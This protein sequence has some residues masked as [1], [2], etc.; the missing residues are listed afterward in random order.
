MI[1]EKTVKQILEE[2]FC[3][4][5]DVEAQSAAVLQFLKDKGMASEEEL[6]PYF[7]QAKTSSGVRW[8]A[9]RAR[10]DYLLSSVIK[11]EEEAASEAREGTQAE[12]SQEASSAETNDQRTNIDKQGDR[13]KDDAQADGREKEKGEKQGPEPP[14]QDTAA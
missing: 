7:E 13:E 2:I 8:V 11:S 1:D 4:V 3:S 6:A 14:V 9:I 12:G 5:E 10:V